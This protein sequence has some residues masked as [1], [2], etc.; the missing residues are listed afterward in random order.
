MSRL[1]RWLRSRHEPLNV[2]RRGLAAKLGL[3]NA[4]HVGAHWAEEREAY[5]AL[6]LANVLWVEASKDNY[7]RLLQHLAEPTSAGTRHIAVHALVTDHP[8][9]QVTL[10]H[11]NGGRAASSIFPATSLAKEWPAKVAETGETEHLISDTLDRIAEAQG[12]VSAD[13]IAAD[14]QGAELLV[15][16]GATR[17]LSTAKCVIV[18]VSRKPYYDGGVLQPELCQFLRS[19]GFMETRSPP[20]HGDQL[21]IRAH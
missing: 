17:L 2:L 9:Q 3:T 14:V 18:E 4:I 1:S 16:K 7:Q 19:K 10:R 11:F 15:L 20:I 6:G 12:F 8:G 13:L 21:Y 5:E